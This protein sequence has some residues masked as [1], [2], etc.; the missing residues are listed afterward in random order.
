MSKKS[1]RKRNQK[2]REE[3]TRQLPWILLAV[4]G[5]ALLVV[6]ILA[7][8]NSTN[9]H[10]HLEL[11][12]LIIEALGVRWIVDLGTEHETYMRH[13]NKNGRYDY[14]R[15]RAEG[16]NTLVLNPKR[17]PVKNTSKISANTG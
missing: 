15:T 11:G 5:F 7:G 4:G 6:G 2:R 3:S 17:A 12:S 1:S 13:R 16:N 8:K 14:Y 9:G 10:R